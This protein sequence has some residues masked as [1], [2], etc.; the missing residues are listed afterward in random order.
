MYV[1]YFVIYVCI[2]S[3]HTAA[4]S[5]SKLNIQYNTIQYNMY[6]TIQYSIMYYINLYS[7]HFQSSMLLYNVC[8]DR[9]AFSS[10][11]VHMYTGVVNFIQQ[12]YYSA[13]IFSFCYFVETG[14]IVLLKSLLCNFD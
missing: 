12:S 9:L 7:A 4:F 2:H 14:I 6:N 13:C 10:I 11:G 3:S 8:H 5:R 1:I